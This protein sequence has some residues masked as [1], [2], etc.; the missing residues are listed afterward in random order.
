MSAKCTTFSESIC[1]PCS[2]D[3]YLDT[4]NEEDKCLLHKVCDTGELVLS[5]GSGDDE[6]LRFSGAASLGDRGRSLTS[7]GWALAPSSTVLV[8][9]YV[10]VAV[11]ME[12]I[13]ELTEYFP[14]VSMCVVLF[15]PHKNPC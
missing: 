10:C 9:D 5:A 11:F 14:G 8:L 2:R 1:L 13:L 6:I 12:H 7:A 15:N 3:E 4:W